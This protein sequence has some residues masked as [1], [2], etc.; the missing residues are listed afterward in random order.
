MKRT[1]WAIVKKNMYYYHYDWDR[2]YSDDDPRISGPLDN[3]ELD[4]MDGQQM[5]YFIYT[6]IQELWND[7]S[8]HFFR[9][10]ERSVKEDV[11]SS[12]K[13]QAEIKRWISANGYRY[14]DKLQK[15][16]RR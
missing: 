16:F 13:G 5:V 4:R 12:I 7:P 11:P 8:P 14:L 6:T 3:T 9:I 1:F 10:I 2:K 15:P